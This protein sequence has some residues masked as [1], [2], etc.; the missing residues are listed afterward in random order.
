MSQHERRQHG[1]GCLRLMAEKKASDVYL[2]ANTPILIKINGQILQLS[3]QSLT[4][5][6]PRQLLAELLTPHAARGARR[7]RRAEHRHRRCRA[8]QLPP[9]S[10]FRQR[11]IDRRGDPLHPASTSR[12]S[13]R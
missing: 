11:G 8:R 13:T 2:S 4:P 5:Q 12:R 6:Q 3:D 9:V 1:D 10:A 7:H